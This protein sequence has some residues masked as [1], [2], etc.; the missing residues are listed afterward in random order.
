MQPQLPPQPKPQ[1]QAQ[2]L[3]NSHPQPQQQAQPQVPPPVPLEL[4]LQPQLPP[5]PPPSSSKARL[6]SMIDFPL[7]VAAALT[8]LFYVIVTRPQFEGTLIR[9]YTCEHIVEYVVVAFFIWGLVDVAFRI[10]AFPMEFMA[11]RHY[12]LTPRGTKESVEKSGVLFSVLKTQPKWFLESRFGQRLVKALGYLQDKQSA[13]G[14]SEYL[15]YL[16]TDDEDRT[17]ANY[18]LLRFICWVAPVLGILGTVIHFGSA[19]GGLSVDEI[20]ANLGKVVG[21]IGTAFNTTTVALAAAISM[22]FCMFVCERMERSMIRTI[23]RKVDLE[24]LN[25]Y[26]VVDETLTPFLHA[27]Q[28]SSQVSVQAMAAAVER[29]LQLW[30]GAFTQ[31]Q[32]K[33]E[34]RL[35]THAQIWEQSLIKVHE[36]FEQSDAAREQ[37][38]TR[39]TDET[40]SQRTEHKAQMQGLLTQI[41]GVQSHFAKLT[42][43]LGGILRGEGE[44]VKLQGTLSDNVRTLRETQQLDQAMHGLTAAIHML[45]ARHDLDP[46]GKRAA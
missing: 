40:Q 1:P 10:C 28:S 34:Q 17:H 30:S 27:V 33:S 23:S 19:F 7:I 15:R 24:L 43:T 39:L 44:L 42:E 11:L 9:R 32:Q 46:K 20:E 14:F 38:L 22:M 16:A 29:Q 37:K 5:P 6:S 45:T 35:Q 2:P 3:P 41:A 12:R 18:A 21:E 25:R 13:D 31:L 8:G 26:E 4:K 36:R